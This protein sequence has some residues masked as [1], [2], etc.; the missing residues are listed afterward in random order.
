MMDIQR[1]HVYISG[2]VQGVFYREWTKR[3]ATDLGL[4][5][6]VKNLPDRRVE[7]VFEGPKERLEEMLRRC[8]D[9]SNGA[10]VEKV[11]ALWE[12]ATSEFKIFEIIYHF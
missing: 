10:T 11:D 7:V 9:G 3:S 2:R 6:W 1:L 12:N 4:C 8:H 5:G